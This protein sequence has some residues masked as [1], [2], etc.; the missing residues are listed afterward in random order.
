MNQTTGLCA[1]CRAVDEKA[2]EVRRVYDTP[3]LA[4]SSF[5]VIPAVGPITPGHVMVVSRNHSPNLGSM[6]QTKI[7]EYRSLVESISK[8]SGFGE[9]LEGEHG[10]SADESG[11]ACITHAHVNLIPGFSHL[12]DMLELNLPSLEVDHDLQTLKSDAAPYILLR[13]G[14]IVRLYRAHAVPSQL[15][16]RVLFAK[17][18]RDDW[19]WG[20]YPNLN[21]V[22]ETLELWGKESHG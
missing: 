12:V 17:V 8:H 3:L 16:R 4:S 18:G 6:G 13:G 14:G 2:P 7:R 5:V 10:A 15:I 1:L 11:G 19:D 20:A 22:Q 21:V 9:L